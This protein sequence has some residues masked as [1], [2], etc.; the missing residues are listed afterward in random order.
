MTTSSTPSRGEI[1]LVDFDP[2]RGHEQAGRRPALIVSD[3]RFNHGRSGLVFATPLTT[4]ERKL[5]THIP[6]L[7]PEGG[8]QRLS[9]IKCE[10]TRSISTDRLVEG[11]WGRISPQTM[12][13]VEERLRLLLRLY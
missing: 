10:D 13:A 4:K 3:D 1:W 11:P 9:F 8:V 7:P 6:L 2:T 12:R 5:P